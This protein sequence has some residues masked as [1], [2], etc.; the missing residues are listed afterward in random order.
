MLGQLSG[1]CLV[2]I[3]LMT[4]LKKYEFRQPVEK[5]IAHK[6]LQKLLN[7]LEKK[8]YMFKAL[9]EF[10]QAVCQYQKHLEILKQ[11]V[12]NTEEIQM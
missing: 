5:Y 6:L 1:F 10:F 8:I 7:I 3:N 2:I 4:S 11:S 12:Q 9:S